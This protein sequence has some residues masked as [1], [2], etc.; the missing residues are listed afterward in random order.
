M[1]ADQ[2]QQPEGRGGE[3]IR[4]GT[5]REEQK[6]EGEKKKKTAAARDLGARSLAATQ[7]RN[8]PE[9]KKKKKNLHG[10]VDTLSKLSQG[11]HPPTNTNSEE[12]RRG[13]ERNS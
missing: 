12:E 4:G 10:L 1:R 11:T 7:E 3:A 9:Q 8:A 2:G 5:R 6:Q 13:R